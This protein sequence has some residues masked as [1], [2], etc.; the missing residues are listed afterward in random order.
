M[1]NANFRLLCHLYADESCWNL[2]SLEADT[3]C[4]LKNRTFI[5]D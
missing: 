3:R 2:S 5:R 4:G 1:L